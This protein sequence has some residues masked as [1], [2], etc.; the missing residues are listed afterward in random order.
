MERQA[1]AQ[2]LFR[3][4]A[5]LRHKVHVSRESFA[6]SQID[7]DETHVRHSIPGLTRRPELELTLG[8]N[9]RWSDLS[10]EILTVLDELQD[11]LKTV[12]DICGERLETVHIRLLQELQGI[13]YGK[14]KS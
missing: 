7:V 6:V 10:V 2:E 5:V 9:Q 13:Q 12:N 11:F 1:Y 3:R 4:V 8:G 14:A